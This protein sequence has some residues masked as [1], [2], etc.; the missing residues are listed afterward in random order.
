MSPAEVPFE[1]VQKWQ[2]IV[3]IVAEIMHVPSALV[4]KVEPPNIK[5][6]VSSE[7]NSNPY[8]RNEVAP[9]NTGLYCETV[10]K[11]R[12]SLLVPDA[13]RDEEWKSNPDIKL[14]MISYL[15]FPVSWPDGQVFGTICVLDRKENSYSEPYRK[16]VLQCRDVLEA[17]LRAVTRLSGQLTRS[18]AYLEEAQRLSHTGSFGWRV[19]TGEIHWS[20]ESFR[21]FGYDQSLTVTLDMVLQRTH[22]EDRLLVQTILDRA[23]RDGKD[24]NYEYRLLMPDGLIKH[25]QVVAHA[26]RDQADQLGFIGAVMDVT[27]SRRDITEKMQAQDALQ[28]ARA[29]L[30]RSAH[31]SRM[32]AMT[33]SI[34]HEINQPLTAV[35][36]MASAGL[37]WLGQTPP[38]TDRARE[39]FD[40]I[41]HAGQRAADVLESVRAMFKSE[42]LASVPI[43]LNQL[44]NDVFTLVQ[45]VVKRQDIAVRTE[46]D[47]AIMPVTGNR[48]Q[49]Q[50]VL[51]N[52]VSNALEA[53]ES[54]AD[55]TIL[56]KSEH[57]NSGQVRV[58]IEDSGTGIEPQHV[59]KIFDPFFT[60][61]GDGMGMGLSICRSIIEAHGGRLW[62]S[63]GRSRGAVFHFTLPT[64]PSQS[65]WKEQEV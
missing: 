14:G 22:P 17:D 30:V 64:S 27:E 58:T 47:T 8:E 52:L 62:A 39:C 51:Y 16:F 12:Q 10:M 42:K 24:F 6:F 38:A 18:E 21:I 11:T 32:G 19:S 20:K 25:V 63:P 57:E 41:V 23:S 33:A 35:V 56:V 2:E 29:E 45:G 37:R 59:D 53:M 50:Q 61:K 48:V 13:L 34:A 31:V 36:G 54:V 15:G 43:D 9:L 49:L 5:V 28:A 7:S 3:N 60:T 55:R 44:I 40:K 65:K 46:L 26:V 4:M 1:T